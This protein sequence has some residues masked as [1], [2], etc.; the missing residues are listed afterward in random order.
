MHRGISSFAAFISS[1]LSHN[2]MLKSQ[3]KLS[4]TG[5]FPNH[6]AVAYLKKENPMTTDSTGTGMKFKV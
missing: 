5:L 4:S 3:A 2:Q 6:V 1:L